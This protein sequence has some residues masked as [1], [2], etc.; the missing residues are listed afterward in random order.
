MTMPS[1]TRDL[2]MLDPSFSRLLSHLTI[3]SALSLQTNHTT[4]NSFPNHLHLNLTII[5]ELGTDLITEVTA[6][7]G[8]TLGWL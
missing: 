1:V 4:S 7:A 6:L 3:G 8:I 2:L 5:L